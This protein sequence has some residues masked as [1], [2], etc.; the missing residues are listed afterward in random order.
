MTKSNIFLAAFLLVAAVF[1]LLRYGEQQEK[2]EYNTLA[3][4]TG[5]NQKVQFEAR[6]AEDPEQTDTGKKVAVEPTFVSQERVL[7]FAEKSAQIEYGDVLQITGILESPGTFNDFNYAEFLAKDGVYA[8]M[9]QPEITITEKRQYA[10][11]FQRMRGG[12]FFVKG[13]L[14]EVLH[15]HL[16]PPRSTILAALLLGDKGLLSDETAEKLNRAGVRHITAIS[17]MHVAV[18]TIYLIPMFLLFGLWRQQAFYIAMGIMT[19]FVL[20]TGLQSSAI[21]AGVMGGMLLFGQHVGRI[22]VSWRALLFAAAGMLAVNPML[23]T[24]DVGFQLSFLA[25]LGII[26]FLPLLLSLFPKKLPFR[27]IIGMTVAAQVFTLPILVYNF[28]QVSVVSFV[29]NILVVPL[30]PFIMGFGF[31]FLLGGLL[32]ET[33]G[34]IFSIPVSLLLQYVSLVVDFFAALPFAAVKTENLSPFWLVLFYA[35]IA[36]FYWKFRKRREFLV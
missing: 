35:G 2:Y 31:L 6:V 34:F 5:S 22:N 13:R 1:G 20:L 24:H 3:E 7:L 12:I 16:S 21:R 26:A 36:V 14:R 9:F 19:L 33:L 29:T 18:L 23:L 11:I 30:L 25:V 27:E 17:G 28:G 15:A 10:N 32:G 4:F 8:V